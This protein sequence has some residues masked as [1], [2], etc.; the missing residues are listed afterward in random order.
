MS[1]WARLLD[2]GKNVLEGAAYAIEPQE[3]EAM[4]REEHVT[5]A[6]G[7]GMLRGLASEIGVKHCQARTRVSLGNMLACGREAKWMTVHGGRLIFFCAECA[8]EDAIHITVDSK[9]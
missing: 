9:P 1:L 8:P 2:V 3:W 5:R 7:A 6:A 4:G